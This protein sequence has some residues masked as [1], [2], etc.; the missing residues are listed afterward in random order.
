MT[1][2]TNPNELVYTLGKSPTTI[3]LSNRVPQRIAKQIA[4]P[5]ERR[6]K[7]FSVVY[8]G[9]TYPTSKSIPLAHREITSKWAESKN[10]AYSQMEAPKTQTVVPQGEKA[11]IEDTDSQLPMPEQLTAQNRH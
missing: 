9:E 7:E 11:Q 4:Y 5:T 2:Q 10:P 8:T 3:S 6:R 1:E